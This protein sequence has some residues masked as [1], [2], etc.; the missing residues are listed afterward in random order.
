MS[1]TIKNTAQTV[2]YT[3]NDG[4]ANT[5]AISLTLI[6]KSL[7]N[8]GTALNTN[9]LHLLENHSNTSANPPPYPIQ[10]QLWWDNTYKFLNV[11][12]GS[13]WKTVYGNLATLSVNGAVILSS[14]LTTSALNAG[15]IGNTGANLV[16]IIN[17]NSQPYITSLGTLSG[18]TVSSTINGSINGS[19]ASAT[20][21]TAATTATTAT[22][23]TGLTSANV[24]TVIG[25]VSTT[26]FP[27]LNQNTTGYA[28]TVSGAAQPNITSIGTLTSLT[29][30]SS[31][32]ANTYTGVAVYA[33]TIGNSNAILTGTLSSASQ[34]NITNVGILNGLT[35][36]VAIVPSSNN[37]VNLGGASSQ[38]WQSIYANNHYGTSF[39]GT[40]TTAKYADLAEKYLPDADYDIG[41]VMMVGGSAEITQHNGTK[42]RAI[43]VISEY[44]AYK[45]NSD[46]DGGVYVALKGRVPVKVIGPVN[47][48][49]SLFGTAHGFAMASSET[50]PTTFAISLENFADNTTGMVEA[51]I[52]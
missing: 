13:I 34:P 8:Y 39:F 27:T 16:G 21:A 24:Q 47:K 17:T 42:I 48:G 9:F 3:V 12:D 38:Y 50:T 25:G 10:G 6:G 4:T 36:S 43:G 52:L 31:V 19:A 14:T 46:L 20:T 29:V 35:V 51:I 18:L 11:Y 26:S 32:Q 37:A 15:T 5:N 30:T 45:M 2:T 28:N 40:S 33:G 23:V 44:P 49:Q 22:Y 1:Y 41:T 7:A